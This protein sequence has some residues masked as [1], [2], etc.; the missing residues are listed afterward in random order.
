M[1][2]IKEGDPSL[3]KKPKHFN[4][5]H[6]GC[7]FIADHTEYSSVWLAKDKWAYLCTCP[8]C[9]HMVHYRS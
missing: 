6:C 9:E 2:I 3:L 1:K 8:T 5:S 7:E 4:C